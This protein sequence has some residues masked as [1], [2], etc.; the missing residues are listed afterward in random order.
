MSAVPRTVVALGAVSLFMDLSSELVHGLLPL[1]LTTVLGASMVA[2]GIVEG[3]AEAT[4]SIVKVFSGALSDRFARRK[5]LVLVGYALAALSKPLFP[6]ATSVPL[7]LVARFADRVGKGVRGAPR[8]ALI[9]DVTPPGQRGAAYGLRQALDTA[10]AVL[11][12]LAAVGLMLVLAGDIR[13]VLWV[14]VLPAIA[15]VAVLVLYVKEPA[16]RAAGERAPRIAFASLGSLGRRYWTIVALGAVL[17]LARFSEAFLV[18]RAHELGLALA[19]VPLVLVLMNLVYTAVAYPAGVAADRGHRRA[20]LLCGI[21]ALI[22][23]DLVI[24]A[25]PSVAALAVGIVLWGA[26]MGLT[27]GL[28]SA[29]VADAAPVQLRG[30]AFGVFHL[31]SGAA[32]LVASV[33]AGWL[34]SALGASATFYAG[35]AFCALALAGLAIAARQG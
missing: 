28:L 29:L 12:P 20:L 21:A 2:V 17:T 34:W 35:A 5:P 13:Q 10:G 19:L 23:A 15:A 25:W 16:R 31:V 26:H 3:I 7:V 6:L 18:L 14:A 4:A 30:T 11:G 1:L 27:Q 9:A 32:L 8:D 24:A 22:A 33:L